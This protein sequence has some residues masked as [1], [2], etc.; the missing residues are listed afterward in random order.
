MKICFNQNYYLRHDL[1]RTIL[2]TRYD[3]IDPMVYSNWTSRIHPLYAM[4]F[5]IVS[6]PIEFFQA[7]KTI[8][9][10]FS[11]SQEKAH[12]ILDLLMNEEGIIEA[13]YKGTKSYFPPKIIIDTEKIIIPPLILYKPE[14]FIYSQ[15]DL[16]SLRMKS[17]P[18]GLVI[19]INNKCR[20]KC[21]YCYANKNYRYQDN[22]SID[23]LKEIL[24]NAK[25]LGIKDIQ[26]IGGEFFL[27]KDWENLLELVCEMGFFKPLI[28][29]KIPL[30]IK[31]IK[32]FERFKTRLQISLDSIDKDLIKDTLK[33]NRNYLSQMINSIEMIDKSDIN[34]QIA[35]VLTKP[36][37]SINNI[38]NIYLFLSQL[39]NLK[40]WEI[41]SVFRSL[42][43]KTNYEELKVSK[44][45]EEELIKWHNTINNDSPF[46]IIVSTNDNSN[47]FMAKNGS[48]S[49]SGPICS[50]NTTH[51]VILPDGKVTICEQLYWNEHFIIGDINKNSIEEIWRGEKALNLAYTPK[52]S[53]KKISP[54]SKCELFDKCMNFP[55]KCYANV[56]KAY[57]MENW[58][59]P[60]PRCEKALPL[61]NPM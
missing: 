35:T 28:S 41:R 44:D 49:F 46:H 23:K 7:V 60:D 16:K 37:A 18:H 13:S 5:A 38:K 47:F 17:S 40:R 30:T 8:A 53:I 22:L 50:A 51:M 45:F 15:V 55:N 27:F 61:I 1:E 11:M 25:E 54:C 10:F 58:D 6:K 42:Y 57:G 36:T 3:C 19:I 34:Y 32:H 14:Q 33:V 31:D 21:I 52:N 4:I 26:L 39:K 29:T 12:S 43:A 59:F 20:T 24:L 48:I 56:L 9:S 2:S